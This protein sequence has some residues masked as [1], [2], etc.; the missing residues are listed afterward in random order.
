MP[1]GDGDGRVTV[2]ADMDRPGHDRNAS[3]Q[4]PRKRATPFLSRLTFSHS[5]TALIV[6]LPTAERAG[7]HVPEPQRRAWWPAKPRPSQA[8]GRATL[9]LGMTADGKVTINAFRARHSTCPMVRS[10][11]GMSRRGEGATPP[12]G[13]EIGQIGRSRHLPNRRPLTIVKGGSKISPGDHRVRFAGQNSQRRVFHVPG[14]ITDKG[15]FPMCHRFIPLAVIALILSA[16]AAFAQCGCSRRR[17]MRRSAPSYA[18]YYAPPAAYDAPVPYVSYYAPA[19]APVSYASYYAPPAA[20]CPGA[21]RQLLCA[22]A[23]TRRTIRPTQPS[24][25]RGALPGLLRGAGPEHLRDAPRLRAGR[26]GAECL[27]AVTP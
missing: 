9:L 18:G 21:L 22:A 5:S 16:S 7:W 10:A 27:K 1:I 25:R 12:R 17:S 11:C 20:Y 13:L 26:T 19:A 3:L 6:T 4:H 8:Q 24:P 2:S 14:F 15:G 23:P